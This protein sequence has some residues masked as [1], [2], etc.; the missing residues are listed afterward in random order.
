MIRCTLLRLI[1]IAFSVISITE[2]SADTK[3]YATPPGFS[4]ADIPVKGTS[5][6]YVRGGQGPAIVLLHGFP[7]DWTEYEAIMPRLA[8]RFTVV[9]VDLPGIGRSAPAAGG[10]DTANLSDYIHGLITALKLDRPYLVGHD[11]GGLVTYAYAR[12]FPDSP[13]GAMILDVPTPGLAGWDESTAPIWLIGFAQVPGL[14][15]KLVPGQQEAFLGYFLGIGKFTPAARAHYFLAYGRTQ[16]HA[17]FEIYRAFGEDAE[18]NAVQTAPNSVPL[19]VA[20]GEKSFFAPFLATFVNGYRAKGMSEVVSARVP[21]ASHYLVADNPEAVADLI[22]R[23]AVSH[24]SPTPGA[25][26][27]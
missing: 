8:K 1:G 5:L 11:L 12:Q 4:S 20:V 14:A 2:A 10:Y 6:H 25:N 9:A 21:S 7:Q 18:L 17:A 23:Y 3:L 15:E 19:V 22:E 13:R 16:L 27:K 24:V 26:G